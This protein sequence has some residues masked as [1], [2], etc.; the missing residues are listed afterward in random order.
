MESDTSME[1]E[2]PYLAALREV[3]LRDGRA[4]L[5]RFSD[6]DDAADLIEIERQVVEENIANVGN[7]MESFTRR[8]KES[9][10]T[11]DPRRLRIVA[12]HEGQVVGVVELNGYGPNFLNHLRM[13]GIAL[14]REWRGCGLGSAMLRAAIEW[15]RFL[16]VEGLILGVLDSNPRAKALYA[17]LGFQEIGRIPH[18][19]KRP[20]G[21][22]SDDTEMMLWLGSRGD[23]AH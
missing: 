16:K 13:I 14:H 3:T 21:S 2:P 23:P 22:Y 1:A 8:L 11:F 10:E 7:D 15:A 9:L 18:F 4:V 19:V 20:D 5:L 17:R 12:E 6:P